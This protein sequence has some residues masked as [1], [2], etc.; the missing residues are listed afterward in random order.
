MLEIT[1]LTLAKHIVNI[2]NLNNLVVRNHND[3]IVLTF[4]MHHQH[5]VPITVDHS[6]AEHV[7]KF[8]NSRD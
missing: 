6:T 1:D 7:M 8:L 4:F 3:C 2:N 5:V